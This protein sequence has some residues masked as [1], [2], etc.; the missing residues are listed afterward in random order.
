MSAKSS[1][2]SIA[3]QIEKVPARVEM[4]RKTLDTWR[5]RGLRMVKRYPGR[6][7]AGAF[8]LAF[9]LGKISRFV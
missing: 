5:S 6:S 9:V 4:A 8:A 2:T 1:V 7:I 3:H